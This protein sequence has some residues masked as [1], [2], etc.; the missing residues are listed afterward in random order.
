MISPAES[1][2]TEA[3]RQPAGFTLPAE[4]GRQP[5]GFTLIEILVVMA[6]LALMMG[7]IVAKG[8]MQSRSLTTR[9]TISAL[10]G[11]LREARARAIATDRPVEFD[12]D[13][14]RKSFHV[15]QAP[16]VQ[17]PAEYTLGF[18]TTA[19]ERKSET[20]AAFRFEP[21]GSSTGGHI[22]VT[23]GRRH[24]QIGVD[25]LSGRVTVADD[26]GGRRR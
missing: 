23:F 17:L 9:D 10:A 6:V 26:Q 7:L 1:S 19:T 20:E 18:V 24:V 21:D 16:P 14:A 12:I 13:T 15:D 25:W 11:G 3:G 4:A 2:A 8:P 22:D 5:A